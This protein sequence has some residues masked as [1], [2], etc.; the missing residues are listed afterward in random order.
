M[1][2]G[3]GIYR[4][5]EPYTL[6]VFRTRDCTLVACRLHAS[7]FPP[8]LVVMEL[9]DPH[10]PRS[11]PHTAPALEVRRGRVVRFG[12]DIDW[13]QATYVGRPMRQIPGDAP[14]ARGEFGNPI[15]LAGDT[16]AER[17][18]V[19]LDYARWLISESGSSVRQRAGELRGRDLVCWCAPKLCHGDVLL[20]F[21]NDGD[22]GVKALVDVLSERLDALRP[23]TLFD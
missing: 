13:S 10:S 9:S 20:A 5:T 8:R 21:V 23:P 2:E 18:A 16:E 14:G 12:T 1:D 22:A 6:S 17:Y 7:V 19:V 4:L 3:T 15:R 11:E